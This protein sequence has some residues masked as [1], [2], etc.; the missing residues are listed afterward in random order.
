MCHQPVFRI[1]W[2]SGYQSYD[3]PMLTKP[4]MLLKATHLSPWEHAVETTSFGMSAAG[5][6]LLRR[7]RWDDM[8]LK[9]LPFRRQKLLRVR[10]EASRVID[11]TTVAYCCRI[12]GMFC[13]DL[14]TLWEHACVNCLF[15]CLFSCLLAPFSVFST[16]MRERLLFSED[17]SE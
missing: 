3:R 11:Q 15:I 5:T 13:F 4:E 1:V 9:R 7:G 6:R 17:L 12:S 16:P 14:E 10:C 8:P 2:R